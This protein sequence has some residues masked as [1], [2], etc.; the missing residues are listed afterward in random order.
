MNFKN[1]RNK[2]CRIMW[3]HRDPSLRKSGNQHMP[4]NASAQIA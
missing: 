3:S 1:I 4:K 2:P